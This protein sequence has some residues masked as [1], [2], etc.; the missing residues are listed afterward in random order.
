MNLRMFRRKYNLGLLLFFFGVRI[1]SQDCYW[2]MRVQYDMDIDFDHEKHRYEG[3]QKLKI[4]N[5]SPD[6]LKKIY[7]HLY[8]NAFQPG[9]DMDIKSRLIED[10]D[11]RVGNRISNLAESEIGFIRPERISQNRRKLDF[12]VDGTILEVKLKNPLMPQDSTIIEMKYLAQVPVQIRRS[13]RNNKEGIDYSM[14]QWY[15]KLCNYDRH[16]WHADPYIGREFYAPWGDFRVSIEIDSKYVIAATGY[17][18]SEVSYLPG[19]KKIKKWEFY[20]PNVHDFVWAADPDYIREVYPLKDGR[21]LQFFHQAN[22]KYDT[23]WMQL[24]KI[25]ER[26]LEFMESHYGRYAYDNYSFIQGGDGGM[27]YPMATLITGNRPLIS[28]VGVSLHEWMHSWFQ[29]MLA[30]N[31]SKYPWMDEGF[32]SYAEDE[33]MNYVKMLGLLPGY[34]PSKNVMQSTLEAYVNFIHS[35]KEEAL[36]TP[37]DHYETNRAYG[38]GSYVKGS[39]TLMQLR[40]IVGEKAFRKGMMN[41]YSHWIFK[42]PEPS[43]FFRSIE[44]ASDIELD[45]FED[46][47]VNTTKRVDYSIDTIVEV[48]SKCVLKIN[49][50]GQFPMPVD[51]LVRTKTKEIIYHIPLDIMRGHKTDPELVFAKPWHWVNPEYFLELESRLD[52]IVEVILDPN[53]QL[54]DIHRENQKLV[55]NDSVLD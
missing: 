23:A 11:P 28:L 12:I 51:V 15:P 42:H 47:W 14:A 4:Y 6:T 45:W 26:A 49:R 53:I 38:V 33:V 44:K 3:E 29:M 13:G 35:G 27:E 43:D 48:N 20:A 36:C 37:A 8:F 10:P 52:E 55:I 21:T 41:Y 54:P 40:Y 19:S 22:P 24:P 31:E 9:S 46:Y 1:Y 7:Y 17:I 25:M 16:G 50:L 5:N 30:T 18:Q 34:E 2:Q 39:L 32:T